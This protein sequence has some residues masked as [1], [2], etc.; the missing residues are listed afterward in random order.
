M[1]VAFHASASA[2]ADDIGLRR[3]DR[4]EAEICM[5]KQ[6]VKHLQKIGDK[7]MEAA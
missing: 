3:M 1:G 2:G 7:K 4:V 6:A 5:L